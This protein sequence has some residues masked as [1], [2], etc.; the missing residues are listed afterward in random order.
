MDLALQ[1]P[2]SNEILAKILGEK[3]RISVGSLKRT[4]FCEIDVEDHQLLIAR[5]GYTGEEIGYEVYTAAPDALWLWEKLLEVGTQFGLKPCGLASRDSTRTEAGL[6]LYGYEL[7]GPYNVNPFEAGFGAYVKLH[8]PF[9]IGRKTCVA[10]YTNSKREIVRFQVNVAG[11]RPIRGGAAVIDKNG[12]YL[13]RVTS[14][15]SLGEAQVGLALFDRCGLAPGTPVILLNPPRD[16]AVRPLSEL[17]VG[18][19]VAIPILG[20][21][22]DRFPEKTLLPSVHGE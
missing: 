17:T 3:E 18:D 15:V 4:E 6:P 12:L 22:I 5:T 21:I 19:R 1:G 8:K 2:L 14:C 16:E 20:R 11:A 10:A 9:F 13:G 7:A